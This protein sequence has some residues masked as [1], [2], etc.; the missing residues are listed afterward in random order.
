MS[1]T[2]R[3][4]PTSL[5]WDEGKHTAVTRD[6]QRDIALELHRDYQ[7]TGLREHKQ[8]RARTRQALKTSD[9]DA[10]LTGKKRRYGDRYGDYVL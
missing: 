2:F 8:Y 6:G 10:V 7:A 1:R 9:Y 4:Q 3:N 5:S